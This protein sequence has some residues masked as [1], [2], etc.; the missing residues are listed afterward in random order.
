MDTKLTFSGTRKTLAKMHWK[1]FWLMLIT[2]GLYRFWFKTNIRRYYWGN[3]TFGDERFE[4]TGTGGELFKGFLFAIAI[5]A[6]LQIA[7]I[8]GSVTTFSVYIFIAIA[9]IFIFLGHFA[10]Y[11]S[12]RYRLNRTLWRGL[13]F[14]MEGSAIKYAFRAFGW[15]IITLLT[16]GFAS[17]WATADLERYMMQRTFFGDIQGDFHGKPFELFKKIALIILITTLPF[18]LAIVYLIS[19]ITFDQWGDIFI[20]LQSQDED[21]LTEVLD[22]LNDNVKLFGT[23]LLGALP[24]WFFLNFL[25]IPAYI[26]IVFRWTTNGISLGAAR[27]SSTFT[28][29]QSYKIWG[30]AILFSTAISTAA[31]IIIGIIIV[32]GV[33][34]FKDTYAT[35]LNNK[36]LLVLGGIVA[37]FLYLMIFFAS[38]LFKA[39]LITYSYWRDQTNSVTL[40]HIDS[41]ENAVMRAQNSSA[42]GEG[43]DAG[44]GIGDIV[45][46]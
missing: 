30:K 22:N 18:L 10:K 32:I 17:P 43:F 26:A 9:L 4:Y 40:H 21:S 29:L 20:A 24:F 8:L 6:P 11:A 44:G 46:I 12:R 16:L 2:F 5:I 3:M 34:A 25:I 41:L 15:S 35:L 28:A 38:W 13:R 7:I 33:F 45:G 23:I 37:I 1:A 36:T 14:R 31:S 27:M 39:L 19:Q 42:L